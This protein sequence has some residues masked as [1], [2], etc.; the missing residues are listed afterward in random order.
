MVSELDRPTGP[1]GR[2]IVPSFTERTAYGTTERDPYNKLFEERI[3]FCGVPIDDTS[4]DDLMAQFVTLEAMDPDRDIV[5]YI[6][7]PGGSFTA[8]MA[9]Y[10][11]MRYIRPPLQTVCVGQAGAAAAVLLA[12]GAPGKRLALPNARIWL[13]QPAGAAQG[14]SSDLEIQAQEIKRM[15][16][17]LESVIAENTGRS[18]DQV[19]SDIERDKI[20][21]PEEAKD[22]GLVDEI[23]TTRPAQ[24]GGWHSRSASSME[25]G[26]ARGPRPDG[27]GPAT[28]PDS[29]GPA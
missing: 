29:G 22:Y 6:N 25:S 24:S 16:G 11:T 13:H 15:R 20:L 12:A 14:Q 4:A 21:T 17:L 18:A 8:F 19:S 28:A 7:S 2:Y 9:V 3:V 10:D 27:E 5:V 26:H 1:A 23:L